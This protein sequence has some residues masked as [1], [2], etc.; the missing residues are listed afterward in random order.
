MT[1]TDL[2][3]RVIKLESDYNALLE[4]IANLT[5]AQTNTRTLADNNK[6]RLE[7]VESLYTTMNLENI[8]KDGNI[9]VITLKNKDE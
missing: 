3:T 4:V 6:F 7:L 8:K 9:L 5:I 1:D 2:E